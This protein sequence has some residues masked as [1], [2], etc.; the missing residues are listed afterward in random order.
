MQYIYNT[1]N[2]ML[3]YSIHFLYKYDTTN[4][5]ILI[6]QFKNLKQKIKKY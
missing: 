5:T 2:I 3:N 1:H 4:I 6:I